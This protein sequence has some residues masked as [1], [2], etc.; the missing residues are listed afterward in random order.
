MQSGE[1][2]RQ[3]T[4]KKTAKERKTSK[5]LCSVALI[6]SADVKRHYKTNHKLFEQTY[7]LKSQ[8]RAHKISSLRAQHDNVRWLNKGRG[9][10]RYWSIRREVA[11]FLAEKVNVGNWMC[12][13][14]LLNVYFF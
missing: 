2:Y 1:S 6:K 13:D 4:K 3:D 12:W 14:S 10:E 8:V 5:A 7:S 9:L 11:S